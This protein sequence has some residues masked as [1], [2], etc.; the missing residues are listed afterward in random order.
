MDTKQ[1]KDLLQELEQDVEVKQ[2]AIRALR[3]LLLGSTD[4]K[5]A[6]MA[7]VV[8]LPPDPGDDELVIPG[9]S[10]EESYVEL[11]AKLIEGM[12]GRP[13]HIR[14]IVNRIRR[15]KGNQDIKRQS[16]ESSLHRHLSSK[17]EKARVFKVGRGMYGLNPPR[18]PRQEPAA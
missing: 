4:R 3:K 17:G 13:M 9:F 16:V 15:I 8:D 14:S 1:I 18:F 2:D 12:G 11:T 7:S 5:P 6:R 10:S